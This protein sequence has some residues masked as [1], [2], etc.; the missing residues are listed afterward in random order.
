MNNSTLQ[1]KIKQRLNK[2]ASQDYD[3]FHCWQI[4][5]AFNK[6]QIEWCRRQLSGKNQTQQGGDQTTRRI[7]DLQI[8]LKS[9]DL[10][11]SLTPFGYYESD[12]LPTD[13]LEF[14]KVGAT[15]TKDCCQDPK[16]LMVYLAEE[17][18]TG[19]YLR[20]ELKKPNFEWA[21]TF[22]TLVGNK[23]RVYSNG[24]F[25]IKSAFLMYYRKPVQIEIANCAN[26][27]SGNISTSD[28][29][30]EFKEDIVEV[31]IDNAAAILAG[32]IESFNQYS[33]LQ[34]NSETNN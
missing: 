31:L 17:N 4:I 7:D 28:V 30:C 24:D 16:T 5:E 33:R 22:C 29:E 21:E 1:I 32:D 13:Y 34:Q 8:L 26:P 9:I 11:L 18:N 19:L 2:L 23:I 20:D 3:N 6:G 15:A 12:V 14:E 27:Y 10:T 25:A